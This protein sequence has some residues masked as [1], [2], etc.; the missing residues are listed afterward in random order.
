MPTDSPLRAGRRRPRGPG[1][2]GAAAL[3]TAGLTLSSCASV[4][5]TRDTE[6]SGEF[7]ASG[8]SFTFLSYDFPKRAIDIARENASD[9]RLSN[10]RVERQ[11]VFPYLGPLDWILD[12]FS[13]RYARIDGRWGFEPGPDGEPIPF[14]AP[15][16][17]WG[18]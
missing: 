16:V 4:S 7:H 3:L 17:A 8:V 1:A 14:D 10:L 11:R 9:S 18:E 13:V 6:T 15:P 2:F 5:F 12:I